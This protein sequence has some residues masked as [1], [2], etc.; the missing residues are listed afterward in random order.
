MCWISRYQQGRFLADLL[1]H[2][3][4]GQVS[5]CLLTLARCSFLTAG[6]GGCDALGRP[7]ALSAVPAKRFART[8]MAGARGAHL[9]YQRGA[10]ANKDTE[11]SDLKHSQQA[12]LPTPLQMLLAAH[13]S[14]RKQL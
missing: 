10:L 6:G 4:I 13:Y 9:Q 7:R 8:S 14:T 12:I 2:Q 1:E 5:L 11:E 3:C